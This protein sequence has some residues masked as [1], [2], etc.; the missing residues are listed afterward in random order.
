MREAWAL[1][2]ASVPNTV[3]REK[4]LQQEAIVAAGHPISVAL[5]ASGLFGAPEVSM[6]ATGEQTG[7]TGRT[8]LQLAHYEEATISRNRG[9]LRV[10]ISVLFLLMFAPLLIFVIQHFA[11]GYMSAILKIGDS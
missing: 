3:I 7:E 6:V 11:E 4:L 9:M 5:G 1:S 2:A 10:G 8:L